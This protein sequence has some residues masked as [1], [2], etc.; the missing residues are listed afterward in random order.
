MKL[1]LNKNEFVN[2]LLGPVSKLADNLLLDFKEIQDSAGVWTAKTLVT[3]SDNSV[4]LMGS[5]PCAVKD[6]F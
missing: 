3:S 1:T 4:I 6:A 2:N 5:V